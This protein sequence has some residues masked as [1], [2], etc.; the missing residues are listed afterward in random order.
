MIGVDC[1]EV[2]I[3]Q[4]RICSDFLDYLRISLAKPLKE[5]RRR[6]SR[7]FRRSV[8][9]SVLQ[10]VIPNTASDLREPNF[11]ASAV[12]LKLQLEI[13]IGNFSRGFLC[14]G[15]PSL[16]N[17][18]TSDSILCVG[19]ISIRVSFGG[20]IGLILG[21]E[22]SGTVKKKYYMCHMRQRTCC[23]VNFTSYQKDD[24]LVGVFSGIITVC[25]APANESNLTRGTSDTSVFAKPGKF[26]NVEEIA[27]SAL[28][29]WASNMP[30][31]KGAA[32]SNFLIPN[33]ILVG[34]QW[35]TPPQAHRTSRYGISTKK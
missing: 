35:P 5:L 25:V 20:G 11:A 16:G 33:A 34:M 32:L 9:H 19:I 8:F 12:K 14:S 3:F 24:S 31:K 21:P 30:R 10:V 28:K 15:N 7:V 26:I 4:R 18:F 17:T 27:F 2:A 22:N 13:E 1:A 29:K 23:H 6:E